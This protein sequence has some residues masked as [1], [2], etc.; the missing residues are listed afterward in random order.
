MFGLKAA[1]FCLLSLAVMWLLKEDLKKKTQ[2][3]LV[4]VLYM[5][6]MDSISSGHSVPLKPS[7]PNTTC[8]SSSFGPKECWRPSANSEQLRV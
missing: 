7:R 2:P 3:F 8:F 5:K 1:G 4:E 6:G